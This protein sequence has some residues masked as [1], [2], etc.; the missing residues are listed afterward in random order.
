MS[1]EPSFATE[2]PL[3]A[4]RSVAKR[5]GTRTVL[6]VPTY[7]LGRGDCV[8]ISGP[9]GSGKST[10]LRVLAGVASASEGSVERSPDY[11]ALDVCYLPQSGGLH[12]N[13]TLADNFRLWLRLFGRTEPEHL[14]AQW[15]VHG[16]DLL[17]FLGARCRDLSGGFQRLAALACVLAT[18]PQGLFIDEPLSGIDGA[19]ARVMVDGLATASAELRFMVITGHSPADFPAAN[20]HLALIDGRPA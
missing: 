16:F 19:H 11:E 4:L 8:L 18:R 1:T 6:E 12:L 14:A 10:L 2:Q 5:Y 20:R 17:P 15:Y 3:I 13:L 7:D 9:N